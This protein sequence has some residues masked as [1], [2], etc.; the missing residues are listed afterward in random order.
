MKNL[1]QIL[2]TLLL[3]NCWHLKSFESCIDV[4]DL[5][6]SKIYDTFACKLQTIAGIGNAL[7]FL[8][9]PHSQVLYA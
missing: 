9:A 2:L 5:E 1:L 3:W 4:F 7:D 8:K 6:I